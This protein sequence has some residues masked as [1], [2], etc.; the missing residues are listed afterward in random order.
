[1]PLFSYR[2]PVFTDCRAAPFLFWYTSRIYGESVNV[3]K[4]EQNIF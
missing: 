3:C 4:I 2:S 1:M